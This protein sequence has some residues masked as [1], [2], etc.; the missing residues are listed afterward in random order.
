MKDH[1]AILE[2]HIENILRFSLDNFESP[3]SEK[4]R[5]EWLFLWTGYL[6]DYDAAKNDGFEPLTMDLRV[7]N[8]ELLKRV[9][10]VPEEF[11][12]WNDEMKEELSKNQFQDEKKVLH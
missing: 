4:V 9:D 1:K 2:N 11:W 3:I 8:E 5:A 12:D 10:E 7:W 6:V